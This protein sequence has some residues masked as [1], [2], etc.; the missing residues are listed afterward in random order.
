MI[1]FVWDSQHSQKRKGKE[2]KGK[3]KGREGKERNRGM[4]NSSE[5]LL[6]LGFAWVCYYKAGT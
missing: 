5:V 4:K 1:P 6:R 2:R 3:E